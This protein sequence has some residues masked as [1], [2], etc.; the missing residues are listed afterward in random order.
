MKNRYHY[1]SVSKAL[2]NLNEQGFSYDFNIH[3][4]DIS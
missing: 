2:Y 4:K 1:G 3:E